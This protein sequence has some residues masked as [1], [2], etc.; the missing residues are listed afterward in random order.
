VAI[1]REFILEL[2][3]IVIS[4]KAIELNMVINP[5]EQNKV[6]LVAKVF[7]GRVNGRG[8]I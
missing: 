1:E 5:E 4:S 8:K 7:A 6:A 3:G 2:S